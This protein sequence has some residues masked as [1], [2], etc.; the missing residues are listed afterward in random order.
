MQ[1]V[2][3]RETGESRQKKRD[4]IDYKKRCE[5]LVLREIKGDMRYSCNGEECHSSGD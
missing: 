1:P 5:K 2:T 3:Q 4:K